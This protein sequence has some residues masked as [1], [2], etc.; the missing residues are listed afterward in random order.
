METALAVLP[1]RTAVAAAHRDRTPTRTPPARP[2][3]CCPRCAPRC[4]RNST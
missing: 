1:L 3:P 4:P 2:S